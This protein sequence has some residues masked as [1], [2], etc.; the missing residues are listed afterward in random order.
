[1]SAS[2]NGGYDAFMNALKKACG[3]VK[4]SMPELIDYEVRIP[5]GG[6]TSALVETLIVWSAKDKV[7]KT[8]GVDSDQIIAAIKASERMLNIIA[9][10]Q[11]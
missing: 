2:G 1:E 10:E 3:R 7:F 5:P 9:R 11:Q 6:K 8:I 4:L